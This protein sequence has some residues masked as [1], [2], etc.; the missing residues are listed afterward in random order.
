M[1]THPQTQ[2]FSPWNEVFRICVSSKFSKKPGSSSS[3]WELSALG[4]V[5]PNQDQQSHYNCLRPIGKR[6]FQF[7]KVGLHHLFLPTGLP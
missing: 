1:R 5:V 3:V 2:A 6:R 4:Q 7:L